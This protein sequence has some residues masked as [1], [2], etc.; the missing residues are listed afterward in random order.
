MREINEAY[1]CAWNG[2]KLYEWHR[3][4]FLLVEEVVNACNRNTGNHLNEV[5]ETIISLLGEAELE[6]AR[7][8]AA[9]RATL[10][11]LPR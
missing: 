9:F 7:K 4:D 2:Q 6:E 11:K 1:W 5:G 10:P 3:D 8:I